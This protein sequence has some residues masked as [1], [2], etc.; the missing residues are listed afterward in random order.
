MANYKQ[1]KNEGFTLIE[2]VV[3][4][5]ILGIL[6]T[7]ISQFLQF[8]TR[9]YAETSIRDQLIS[10]ARFAIERLNRD[11]RHAVPNSVHIDDEDCLT[12]IPF[13][14][15]TIYTDIPV[16]P[17]ETRNTIDVIQFTPEPVLDINGYNSVLDSWQ[18]VVYPLSRDDVFDVANNKVHSLNGKMDK[19]PYPDPDKVGIWQLELENS[20]VFEQDSPT[21]RIFFIVGNSSVSYCLV[22]QSLFRNNILMAQNITNLADG[23]APFDV[24]EST[25]QRNAVVQIQLQFEQSNEQVTFSNEVQVPNVP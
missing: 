1:K 12:F 18:A 23:I 16:S 6:A 15:S 4:I 22:G 8:G 2:L 11:L 9:I 14:E 17:E 20:V 10:S 7:G 19:T 24:Q 13:I 21:Q 5:V 25:L 3:V